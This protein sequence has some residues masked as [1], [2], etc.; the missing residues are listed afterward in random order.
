[1]C[2]LQLYKVGGQA[3]QGDQGVTYKV[4]T[5]ADADYRLNVFALE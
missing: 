1:M 4:I 3:G 5:S 2:S